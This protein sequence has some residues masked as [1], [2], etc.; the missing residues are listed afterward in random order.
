MQNSKVRH[1]T[2]F[3]ILLVKLRQIQPRFFHETEAGELAVS[4]AR[5]AILGYARLFL[6]EVSRNE[7]ENYRG[8][9]PAARSTAGLLGKRFL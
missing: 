7:N 8:T 6:P 2:C 1:S 9:F 5:C 3:S 4:A